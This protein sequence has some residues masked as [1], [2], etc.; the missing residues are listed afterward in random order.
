MLYEL[1]D[2]NFK[3]NLLKDEEL[4]DY[5]IESIWTALDFDQNK[6]QEKK[7]LF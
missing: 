4:K 6:L 1:K 3:K 5:I 2:E 7:K